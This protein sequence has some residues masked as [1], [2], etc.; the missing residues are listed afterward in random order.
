MF[1]LFLQAIVS[2]VKGERQGNSL[3]ASFLVIAGWPLTEIQWCIRQILSLI[4][5]VA[6][7]D[8]VSKCTF[9]PPLNIFEQI[10]GG[11][12]LLSY[13]NKIFFVTSVFQ[14]LYSYENRTAL[15]KTFCHQHWVAFLPKEITTIK[16]NSIVSVKENSSYY[17]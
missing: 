2:Q 16:S 4:K 6:C 14:W 9:S 1:Y 10:K 15:Q 13:L 11:S 7:T 17:I 12:L 5:R 8:Q 3:C